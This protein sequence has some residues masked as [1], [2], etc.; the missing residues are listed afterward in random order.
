MNGRKFRHW[1][2]SLVWKR[3]VKATQSFAKFVQIWLLRINKLVTRILIILSTSFWFWAL[4]LCVFFFVQIVNHDAS[5]CN[6]VECF[7]FSVCIEAVRGG[8]VEEAQQ[9]QQ[10]DSMLEVNEFEFKI[11]VCDEGCEI[12]THTITVTKNL[13]FFHFF[14]V[15]KRKQTN[16][17]PEKKS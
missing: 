11:S 12:L 8:K 14:L 5:Q 9:Y 15:R 10:N 2:S 17:K 6:W 4:R 16:D 3:F 1:S 7:I 13:D